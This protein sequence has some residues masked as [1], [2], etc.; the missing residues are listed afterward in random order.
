M[1]TEA[2][3]QSTVIMGGRLSLKKVNTGRYTL[4]LRITDLH[5]EKGHGTVTRSMDFIVIE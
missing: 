2:G 3:D 5:A 4:G 1:A